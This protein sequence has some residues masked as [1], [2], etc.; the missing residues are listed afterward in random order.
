[1]ASPVIHSTSSATGQTGA[2]FS[3]TA[4]SGIT[5]GDLLVAIQ[6]VDL[7]A[8]STPATPTGWTLAATIPFD[9]SSYDLLVFTKTA[10]SE[11]GSYTWNNPAGGTGGKEDNKLCTET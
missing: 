11:P 6:A 2:T 5:N 3:V 8:G 7:A 10:A 1:M 9:T 4:P